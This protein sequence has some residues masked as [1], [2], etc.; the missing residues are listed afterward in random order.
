[1]HMPLHSIAKP[2][3]WCGVQAK[4]VSKTSPVLEFDVRVLQ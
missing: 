1:M 4:N 3:H 2:K